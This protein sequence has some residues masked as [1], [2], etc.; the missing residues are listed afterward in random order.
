VR[1]AGTPSPWV[2]TACRSPSVTT[3]RITVKI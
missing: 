3:S 1:P 2:A